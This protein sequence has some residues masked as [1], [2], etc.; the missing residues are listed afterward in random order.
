MLRATVHRTVG[1]GLAL[2]CAMTR[3]DTP[4]ELERWSGRLTRVRPGEEL[5]ALEDAAELVRRLEL[6]TREG[7]IERWPALLALLD[8]DA[9]GNE[10]WRRGEAET[11]ALGARVRE[12]ALALGGE[13]LDDELSR[14]LAAEVLLR[15]EGRPAR[16]R[17]A[18]AALLAK[19]AGQEARSFLVLATRDSEALVRETALSALVG[20]ASESVHAAFV[21]VLRFADRSCEGRA[22]HAAEQHFQSAHLAAPSTAAALLEKEVADRLASEDWREISRAAAFSRALPDE[23]AV[24][25]LIDA[26]TRWLARAAADRSAPRL[27]IERDLCAELEHRSGRT[28]G[29]HPDRWTSWWR[30]VAEGRVGTG[31]AAIPPATTASFFGLHPASDR[32]TFVLDRS[33][34]M[35]ARFR[36]IS[37]VSSTTELSRYEAAV[38][39]L[40]TYL[41]KLGENAAFNVVLFHDG[42]DR[43]RG[44][45]ARATP[46][47]LREVR[48]WLLR[49]SPDGG[50]YLRCGIDEALDLDGGGR[51][52]LD[53]MRADSIV[54]LCDGATTEG[55]EW[56]EPYLPDLVALARL[57]FHCVQIGMGGDGT[58]EAL[59]R[60]SGGEFVRVRP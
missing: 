43:W 17:A 56:V 29:P 52:H 38:E 22:L 34:S 32:V 35:S 50:T 8:L 9:A 54:V 46:E 37:G 24:P 3:P 28:L 60:E 4:S 20:V 49:R 42:A 41:A 55:P 6:E 23:P 44:D 1:I 30:A 33:G 19:R 36:T 7:G 26:L 58:L 15:R 21:D 13:L 10:I 12:L 5:P 59:A 2:L 48:T 53:R 57:R 16:E 27:R 47:N 51:L 45:A 25:L 14:R 18:A 31:S 39:E 40:L 11:A